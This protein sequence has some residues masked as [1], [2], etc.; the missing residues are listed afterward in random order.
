MK[1]DARVTRVDIENSNIVGLG[2]VTINDQV[3]LNS[4]RILSGED[5]L[6]VALP[7]YKTSKADKDTGIAEYKEFY[8]AIT[9]EARETFNDVVMEAYHAD[10]GRATKTMEDVTEDVNFDVGYGFRVFTNP[11]DKV[12]GIG[13]VVLSDSFVLNCIKV[14]DGKN[15]RFASFPSYKTNQVDEKG[16]TV[17]QN[18]FNMKK[19]NFEDL[20][21]TVISS[22]ENTL[23]KKQKKQ[24]AKA[25]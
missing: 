10:D 17:Y 25:K 3:Y 18:Y 8:H 22:F 11:E 6:F 9:A 13:S 5:G 15:G 1:L 12:A 20:N 19:E 24:Q 14:I 16:N 2:T 21:K 4:V 23:Q 7:S